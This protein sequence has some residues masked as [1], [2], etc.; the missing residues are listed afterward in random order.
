MEKKRKNKYRRRD[1]I[2]EEK[3]EIG[4]FKLT[5]IAQR[6]LEFKVHKERGGKKKVAYRCPLARK[7]G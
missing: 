5:W 7:G 6:D 3:M 2:V 4:V 1:K